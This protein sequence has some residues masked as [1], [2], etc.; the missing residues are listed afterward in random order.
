MFGLFVL[1]N[2]GITMLD[3]RYPT[4]YNTMVEPLYPTLIEVGHRKVATLSRHPPP[5]YQRE[6][7]NKEYMAQHSIILPLPLAKLWKG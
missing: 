5:A 6:A 7:F 2:T 1:L 3:P 4:L